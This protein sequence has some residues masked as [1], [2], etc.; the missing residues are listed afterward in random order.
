MTGLTGETSSLTIQIDVQSPCPYILPFL[1]AES[2]GW[3]ENGGSNEG[4]EEPVLFHLATPPRAQ[5]VHN[6]IT[7]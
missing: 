6:Y 1:L 5:M 4:K 7:G 2:R 3:K